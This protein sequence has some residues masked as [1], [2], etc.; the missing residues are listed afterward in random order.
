MRIRTKAAKVRKDI[1]SK[2][3]FVELSILSDLISTRYHHH[4][5]HHYHHHHYHYSMT[6]KGAAICLWDILLGFLCF[7]EAR[8]G[9]V[10]FFFFF[11]FFFISFPSSSY[12]YLCFFLWHGTNDGL[13]DR[14][15]GVG[16]MIACLLA[17]L[18]EK[19]GSIGCWMIQ[20]WAMKGRKGVLIPLLV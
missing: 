2:S 18:L 10:G 6:Y 9:N 17:C 4:A 16:G 5:H 19:K 7:G 1:R 20:A 13:M 8:E 14:W 15:D 3:A 12:C 11:N